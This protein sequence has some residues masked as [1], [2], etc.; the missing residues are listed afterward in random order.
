MEE[1]A[2]GEGL[3]MSGTLITATRIGAD[4]YASA[5][6]ALTT[7]PTV[8]A[9]NSENWDSGTVHDTVTNNSRLTAPQ[10]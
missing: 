7:T 1:I 4:V 6:V 5:P 8:V 3:S 10:A 2:I 9:C